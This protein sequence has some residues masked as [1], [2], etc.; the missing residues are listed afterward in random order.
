MKN[1]NMEEPEN[2]PKSQQVPDASGKKP[3]KVRK[4]NREIEGVRLPILVEFTYTISLL[5]LL[6][7]GLTIAVTSFLHGVGLFAV[8]LRTGLAMLVIG[9]LLML[10]ASQVSSGMLFASLVEQEEHHKAGQAESGNS[11]GI[12]TQDKAKAS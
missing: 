12:E 11:S 8:V 7:L 10:I 2:T 5:I 4:D 3:A 9:S 6:V 1:E